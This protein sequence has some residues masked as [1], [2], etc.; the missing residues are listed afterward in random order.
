M[1]TQTFDISTFQPLVDIPVMITTNW[2]S[3]QA[4]LRRSVFGGFEFVVSGD[5]HCVQLST[6]RSWK[7]AE[8]NH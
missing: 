1:S 8:T 7:F 5:T 2:K 4:T 6:I 3:Y